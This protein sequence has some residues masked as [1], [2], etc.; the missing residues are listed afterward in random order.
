VNRWPLVLSHADVRRILQRHASSLVLTVRPKL[1]AYVVQDALTVRRNERLRKAGRGSEQ[2]DPDVFTIEITDVAPMWLRDLDYAIVRAAG[3]Q[4]QRDF[5]DDWLGR[6][7]HID[8]D[9]DVYVARFRPAE[10]PRFLHRRTFSGYTFEPALAMHGEPE[11]LSAEQ[12]RDLSSRQAVDRERRRELCRQ[13][14]QSIALRVRH[15]QREGKTDEV[16]ALRDE[17]ERL[18]YEM[19]AA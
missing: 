16:L 7:G 10:R 9:Q 13:R 3:W 2:Q 14:A 15:A 8:P 12:L 17:L 5:F 6:K 19:T 4:T 11:A 1:G 18:A